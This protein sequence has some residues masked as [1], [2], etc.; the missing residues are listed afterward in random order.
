MHR[1]GLLRF[2]LHITVH[3]NVFIVFVASHQ[4]LHTLM[5]YN[6]EKIPAWREVVDSSRRNLEIFKQRH[7]LEMLWENFC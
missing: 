4:N 5:Y 1:L 3:R 6:V 2:L 7:L